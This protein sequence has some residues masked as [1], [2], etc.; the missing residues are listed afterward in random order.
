[1]EEAVFYNGRAY[2]WIQTP[3]LSKLQ[4]G[5]T[6]VVSWCQRWNIKINEGKSQA[7]YF[8][9]RRR[10]PRDD[11]QMNG[12]NIPFVNSAEYLGVIFDRRLTWRLYIEGTSAKVLALYSIFKSKHLS[13]DIKLIV[14]RALI[15]SI[16]TYA[17]PTWE[18]AVDTHLMK[19][20]R[21]QN[22]VP[23]AIG[24]A[25][26]RTPVHDLHLKKV[27]LSLCLTN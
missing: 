9:R 22:R 3:V 18:F 23:H 25:D 14:C 16:M 6:A 8:S 4:R 13:A 12:L 2:K 5:L 11:L 26:S 24:N 21:L 19:L 20:L 7:I 1:M 10:M 15:R 27:K 17:R